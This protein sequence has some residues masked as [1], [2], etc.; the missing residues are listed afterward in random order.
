MGGHGRVGVQAEAFEPGA[1]R[2]HG[3]R[4]GRRAEPTHGLAHERRDPK[5]W[6]AVTAGPTAHEAAPG[7]LLA[8]P[9]EDG[10]QEDAQHRARQCRVEGELIAHGHWHGEHPLADRHVREDAIDQLRGELA[11]P[12]AAA[13]RTK[14]APFARAERNHGGVAAALTAKAQEAMPEDPTLEVGLELAPDEGR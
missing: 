10:A 9:A 6:T 4:G 13:G 8:Q 1:A 14:R 3:R 11:H 2:P 7:R 5:R 12:P